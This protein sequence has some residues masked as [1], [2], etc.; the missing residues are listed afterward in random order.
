MIRYNWT[1]WCRNGI[2]VKP[3][4]CRKRMHPPIVFSGESDNFAYDISVGHKQD[5]LELFNTPLYMRNITFLDDEKWSIFENKTVASDRKG[6]S[7][8]GIRMQRRMCVW[9][10]TISHPKLS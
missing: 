6:V 4:D 5:V 2:L 9:N 8:Y 7:W 3:Q 10:S 1:Y